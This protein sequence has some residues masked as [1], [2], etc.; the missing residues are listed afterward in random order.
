MSEL[1]GRVHRSNSE[2]EIEIEIGDWIRRS[3]SEIES[4]IELED[5]TRRSS[6]G[7]ALVELGGRALGLGPRSGP[8]TEPGLGNGDPLSSSDRTRRSDLWIPRSASGSEVEIL[9]RAPCL[10][11][12]DRIRPSRARRSDSIAEILYRAPR[13]SSNTQELSCRSWRSDSASELGGRTRRSN[14]GRTWKSSSDRALVRFGGR[15]RPNRA[16][17]PDRAL[18]GPYGGPSPG[19]RIL[20]AKVPILHLG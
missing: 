18:V 4:E 15:I 10:S 11:T 1:G 5:R 6:S 16:Q 3:K 7:R 13:V 19:L 20:S 17:R 8:A 9:C 2:I 14:P 12:D